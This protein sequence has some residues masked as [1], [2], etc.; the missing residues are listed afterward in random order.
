MSKE[1]S[2]LVLFPS[3]SVSVIEH[4]VRILIYQLLRNNVD[5]IIGGSIEIKHF[6]HY[7]IYH[8]LRNNVDR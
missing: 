5:S 2:W 6:V 8:L 7:L 4:F 3:F 1:T